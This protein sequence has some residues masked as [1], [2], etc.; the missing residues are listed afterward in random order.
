MRSMLVCL[1]LGFLLLPAVRAETG[2]SEASV[3]E[4]IEVTQSARMVDT[5]FA[6]MDAMMEQSLAQAVAGKQLNPE[7]EKISAEMRA[8]MFALLKEEMSWESLEPGFIDIYRRSFS[9]DEID[10]MLEFYKSDAGKAVIEKMPLV[11][12]ES[13]KITQSRLGTLMPRIQELTRESTRQLMEAKTA[14]AAAD[15]EQ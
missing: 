13:M 2:A 15:P 9:Q 1:I 12:Q 10:G 6:Q 4:L 7:Q 3:R 5:M 8:R 11:M 14:A